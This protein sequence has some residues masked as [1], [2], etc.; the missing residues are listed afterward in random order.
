MDRFPCIFLIL[1]YG[2]SEKG[3]RMSMQASLQNGALAQKTLAFCR[4]IVALPDFAQFRQDVEAFLKDE[5]AQGLYRQ[6]AEIGEQL[7]YKQRQG[8]PITN[9]E[10]QEY[11]QKREALLANEVARRFLQAQETMQQ[12]QDLVLRYVTKTLELGHVP[13]EENIQG[14]DLCGGCSS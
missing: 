8:A 1:R 14:C 4:E 13:E 12:V 9:E 6:A 10:L 5:E 7:Y 3:V 2:G 11:E